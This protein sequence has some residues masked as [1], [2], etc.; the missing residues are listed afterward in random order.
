[1]AAAT[2]STPFRCPSSVGRCSSQVRGPFQAETDSAVALLLRGPLDAALDEIDGTPR[3]GLRVM[4]FAA[5]Q[6]DNRD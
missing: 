3:F 1:M 2:P 4:G 6:L 5:A